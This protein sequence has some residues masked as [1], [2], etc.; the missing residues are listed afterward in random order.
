[1]ALADLSQAL[2]DVGYPAV[3]ASVTLEIEGMSCASCV[4]RL[5]KAL[6]QGGGVVDASVNLATESAQI[7]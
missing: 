4:G 5:E 1:M 2:T 7:R 3:L 6:K